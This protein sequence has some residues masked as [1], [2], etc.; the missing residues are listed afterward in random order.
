[1]QDSNGSKGQESDDEKLPAILSQGVSETTEEF[2]RLLHGDGDWQASL[3]QLEAEKNSGPEL[4]FY[5]FFTQVGDAMI[6][7]PQVK[8]LHDVNMYDFYNF[9]MYS[10]ALVVAPM[11]GILDAGAPTIVHSKESK[12]DFLKA[13]QLELLDQ[14]LEGELQTI[15][16][17]A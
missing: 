9:Y 15:F 3:A 17:I 2:M 8:A 16:T 12:W 11:V 4:G 7:E 13:P 1:M 14:Q 6:T 10:E 5:G